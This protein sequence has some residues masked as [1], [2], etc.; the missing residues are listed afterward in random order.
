M[1]NGIIISAFPGVGK[2]HLFK[3]GNLDCCDS[4]SSTF[5]KAGF[6]ANYIRAI[7]ENQKRHDFVFVSSHREVREAIAKELGEFYLVYPEYGCKSE[8]LDRYKRRGSPQSF[9]KL[10]DESWGGFID[11]CRSDNNAEHIELKSGQYLGDVIE[12]IE[13]DAAWPVS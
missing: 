2:S 13:D 4:D 8:Y 6:P 3:R 1:K 7:R 11:D 10:I 5:D 9:I 12:H